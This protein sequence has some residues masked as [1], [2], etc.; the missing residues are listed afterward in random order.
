MKK[1]IYHILYRLSGIL[2]VILAV[3][4]ATA[5]KPVQHFE[6][7]QCEI[8]EF[9]VVDWPGDRYTW[10]LYRDSSVNFATTQGDVDPWGYFVDTYE[11]STVEVNWLEAG[12]YFLR[13]MVWDEV[14]C[15]NN[16]MVF[17]VDV[18]E[19]QPEAYIVG[20]SACIGD[21]LVMKIVFTGKGPWGVTYTY[22]NET[23]AVNLNGITEPE[24]SVPLPTFPVGETE[25]WVMEVTDQ[26]NVNTY[27]VPEKEPVV[28]HPKPTNSRIYQ[29]DK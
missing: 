7:D 13:V 19:H 29:V 5:Q 2:L 20:D 11:G 26:C 22:G 10:D 12:R 4:S 17:S 25:F 9:S 21:P 27:I 23:N 14:R 15:T 1:L 8:L 24:Y 6:V 18:I 28:V 3:T 16:L